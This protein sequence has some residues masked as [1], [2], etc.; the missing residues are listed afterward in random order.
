M[1]SHSIWRFESYGASNW[2]VAVVGIVR[3]H[4]AVL[5]PLLVTV[6]WSPQASEWRGPY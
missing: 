5:A 3:R 2:R 4:I 6:Y 1:G